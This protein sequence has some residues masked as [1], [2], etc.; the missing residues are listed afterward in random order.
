M[1]KQ[2]VRARAPSRGRAARCKLGFF[3]IR[4]RT[5]ARASA[6]HLCSCVHTAYRLYPPCPT[7]VLLH[8]HV[9]L[10]TPKGLGPAKLRKE[11]ITTCKKKGYVLLFGLQRYSP[12]CKQHSCR[13]STFAYL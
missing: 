10:K 1:G 3:C 12:Y 5:N 9:S 4:N 7:H 8:L 13:A 2:S 11:S 6:C